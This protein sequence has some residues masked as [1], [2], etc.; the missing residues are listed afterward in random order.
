MTNLIMLDIKESNV[1]VFSEANDIIISATDGDTDVK[2]KLAIELLDEIYADAMK[3]YGEPTP[4]EQE[5]KILSLENRN[6]ELENLVEQYQE[7]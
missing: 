4:A 3:L 1:E 6:E 2:L 5:D 7:R